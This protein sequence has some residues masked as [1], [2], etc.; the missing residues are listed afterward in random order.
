MPEEHTR[1]LSGRAHITKNAKVL[2]EQLTRSVSGREHITYNARYCLRTL[3]AYSQAGSI[4]NTNAKVLYSN[5]EF[6]QGAI[7]GMRYKAGMGL[8]K[9]EYDV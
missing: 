6:V 3:H 4:L 2:P 7:M 9:P 5:S 1:L 8:P